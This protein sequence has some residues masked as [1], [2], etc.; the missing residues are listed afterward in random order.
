MDTVTGGGCGWCMKQIAGGIHMRKVTL[1]GV[2][3]ACVG[4]E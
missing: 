3:P 1:Q 4:R 2:E